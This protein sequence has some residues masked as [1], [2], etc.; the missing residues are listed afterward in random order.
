MSLPELFGKSDKR[1]RI[2]EPVNF[3]YVKR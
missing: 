1:I 3:F 2:Y